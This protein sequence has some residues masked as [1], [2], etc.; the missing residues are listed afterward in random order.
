[1][2]DD[3]GDDDSNVEDISSLF[4]GALKVVKS[5][6]TLRQNGIPLDIDGPL[7]FQPIKVQQ[8]DRITQLPVNFWD[9]L[10]PTLLE[11]PTTCSCHA[12]NDN[13]ENS[14]TREVH[15]GFSNNTQSFSGP[16]IEWS[17]PLRFF[18]LMWPFELFEELA[19]N[20]NKYAQF[21]GAK[22]SHS[23]PWSQTN[24]EELM[25]WVELIVYMG[26]FNRGGSTSELWSRN[27]EYL[28]HCISKFRGQQRF[29]QIKRFFHIGGKSTYNLP[30]ERFF[31][32]LD[33]LAFKLQANWESAIT[34]SSYVSLDEMM[35]QFTGKSSHTYLIW[36]KPISVGYKL[37]VLCDA[38]YC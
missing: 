16:R 19:I 24:A 15:S 8:R 18:F 34:L 13:R 3:S 23:C 35:I 25:I 27:D 4:Q 32:K 31:E 5:P 37:H 30:R 22:A 6:E 14:A 17:T 7:F 12:C 11:Q 21:K 9:W 33:P 26:V 20:I 28:F 36:T 38:G 2:D 29:E 10:L 1:M